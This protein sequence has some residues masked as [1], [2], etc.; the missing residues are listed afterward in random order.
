MYSGETQSQLRIKM[1]LDHV[2]E[3]SPRQLE[4]FTFFGQGLSARQI[5][6]RMNITENTV[7]LHS[8]RVLVVLGLESRLQAG[9]AAYAYCYG[10]SCGGVRTCQCSAPGQSMRCASCREP[11]GRRPA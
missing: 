2:E 7:K 11:D 4:V 6:T 10:C 3:L 9:I 5:A 1:A 8:G